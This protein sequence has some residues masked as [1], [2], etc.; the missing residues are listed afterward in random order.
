MFMFYFITNNPEMAVFAVQNGVDRIFVDLEIIGKELRQGHLSTVISR[1]SID[2]VAAVRKAIQTGELVV[3]INPVNPGTALEIDQVIAAGADIIMLPM[4][5]GPDEVRFFCS[6]V[7][8]RAKTILLVE[9]VAA[10]DSLSECVSVEGVN[11]VHIG[12]NDLHLDLGQTF[13]FEPLAAGLV[14][15]MAEILRN[16]MIP[17]GFGGIARIGEGLLP[18]EL[19][20]AEHARLGS[21][22]VIISRTFHRNAASVAEIREQ[23]DFSSELSLL[24]QSYTE[25]LNK[26]E[27]ELLHN[28]QVVCQRVQQ[29][30][31]KTVGA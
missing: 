30:V 11:E 19:I 26:S 4:F 17:F 12:L 14:D 2:D 29:I 20:L 31:L 21:T 23:M 28:H 16:S 15:R 7:A 25:S 6:H 27:S 24:K 10:M 3:R 9:T 5:S 1:H 8:G 22:A 18:A 13:M